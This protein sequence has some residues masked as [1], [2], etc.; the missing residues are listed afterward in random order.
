MKLTLTTVLVIL[1]LTTFS[2]EKIWNTFEGTRVLNNHSTEMLYKHN[3]EIIIAHKFG[4]IAGSNGGFDNF[5]G[6]DNLADVRFGFEYGATTNFDIGLGRNKGVNQQTQV[7]DGY[8]KYRFIQQEK[9][10]KPINLTFVSSMAFVGRKASTDSTSIAYYKE[11]LERLIFTNQILVSRKMNQRL[12]LQINVGYHHRN[13]VTY[14]DVNGMIFTGGVIRYRV[15]QTFGLI[16]EY[17]HVWNRVKAT[18][19]KNPLSVGFELITGGHNFTI[20]L[21][22]GRGINENLFLSNTYSDWL[23]GQ[24]RIGFSINRRFKL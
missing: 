7:I 16:T 24:W 11:P 14:N 21:S 6:F 4:D 19:Q 13:L 3:L 8:A 20:V 2:Q 23:K 17:N 9:N 12:S 22:N 5:F 10:G 15:T 1:G 18:G